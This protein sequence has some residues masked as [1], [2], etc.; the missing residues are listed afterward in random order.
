MQQ[1]DAPTGVAERGEALACVVVLRTADRRRRDAAAA[2]RR[3]VSGE[4][5]P[6]GTDFQEV[7]GRAQLQLVAQAL[8]LVVLRTLQRFIRMLVP[9]ARV[10][11]VGVE[12]QLEELIPEIVVR[13]DVVAAA[14]ARVRS[15][16]M[17]DARELPRQPRPGAVEARECVAIAQGQPQQG[18]EIRRRPLASHVRLAQAAVAREDRA[19]EHPLVMHGHHRAGAGPVSRER[20]GPLGTDQLE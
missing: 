16:E 9:G 4:R 20:V 19:R 8:E 2:R 18:N 5:A 6:A 15:A 10:L 12:E 17:R 7:V 3:R 14:A 1:R 11:Q 13:G